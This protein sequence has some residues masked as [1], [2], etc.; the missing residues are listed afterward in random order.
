VLT[1]GIGM[2]LFATYRRKLLA[3][4]PAEAEL[5]AEAVPA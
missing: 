3:P 2:V 1:F 5:V 4:T